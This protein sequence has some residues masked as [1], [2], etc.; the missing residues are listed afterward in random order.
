MIRY[1]NQAVKEIVTGIL[2]YGFVCTLIILFFVDGGQLLS[3]LAGLALGIFGS[4]ALLLHMTVTLE[5]TVDTM[6]EHAA[7]ATRPSPT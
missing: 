3:A 7:N 5:S 6:D 4:A 1:T 2:I